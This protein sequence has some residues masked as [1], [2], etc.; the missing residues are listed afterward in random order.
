MGYGCCTA[1][2]GFRGF[3]TKDEKIEMLKEYK[4]TLEKEAKGVAERIKE[5]EKNN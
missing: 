2:S 3:L 5:M 4:E 1:E